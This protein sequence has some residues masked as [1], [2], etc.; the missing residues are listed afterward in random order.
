MEIFTKLAIAAAF[1]G[2]CA[3]AYLR[4]ARNRKNVKR[5]AVMVL[6]SLM[7]FSFLRLISMD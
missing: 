2:A 3:F 7:L 4:L 5:E 1:S 6:G